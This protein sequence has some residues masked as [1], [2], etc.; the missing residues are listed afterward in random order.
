[1]G[2]GIDDDD[3]DDDN[4]CLVLLHWWNHVYQRM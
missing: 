3:G 2:I 4:I 1:M